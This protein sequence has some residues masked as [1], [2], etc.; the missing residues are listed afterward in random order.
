MRLGSVKKQIQGTCCY[1][2]Q[3]PETNRGRLN[4]IVISHPPPSGS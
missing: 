1:P 3:E 4:R 2:S